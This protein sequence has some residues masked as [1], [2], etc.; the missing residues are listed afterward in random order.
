MNAGAVGAV[1]AQ[2]GHGGSVTSVASPSQG[3]STGQG[4]ESVGSVNID[5]STNINVYQEQN[6]STF[7]MMSLRTSSHSVCNGL[8]ASQSIS[9]MGESQDTQQMMEKLIQLMML[10]MM[11]QMMEQLGGSQ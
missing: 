5:N 10:M 4:A 3:K 2:G 1:S 9:P 8:T 6:M 11:M 7:D